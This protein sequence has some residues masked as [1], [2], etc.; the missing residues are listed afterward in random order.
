MNSSSLA[1]ALLAALDLP[2]SASVDQRVAKTSLLE[3]GAPTARDKRLITDGID[4]LHWVASLKANTVGVPTYRDAVREVLEVQVMRLSVKPSARSPRLV[5][6]VHR[7]IPYPLLLVVEHPAGPGV[8]AVHKRWSEGEEGKTVLD[9]ELV[10]V[11][12]TEV[13][14][15]RWAAF[16]GALV[17]ARQPRTSLFALYQGWLDACQALVASRVTGAF[18]LAKTPEEAAARREAL[19]EFARLETELARVRAAAEA[20]TQLPRQ[21]E[22]NLEFQRLVI[23]QAE[24]R[25]KL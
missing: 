5:E 23:A 22:L 12:A 24:V 21:V 13:D 7:A 18:R 11:A 9:G 19:P 20:E 14:A 2:S 17:L 3:Y 1:T 16:V 6:L 15:G 25:K 10:E 8:S 4:E